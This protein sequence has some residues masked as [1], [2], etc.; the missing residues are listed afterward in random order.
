VR[1]IARPSHATPVR[2]IDRAVLVGADG[3]P[4]SQYLWV[5][6]KTRSVNVIFVVYNGN[7][8]LFD[9]VQIN[10]QFELGGRISSSVDANTVDLELFQSWSDV[11]RLV[12]RGP[13]PGRATTPALHAHTAFFPHSPH[14]SFD[15]PE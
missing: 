3:V 15:P 12:H 11:G 8:G 9:V 13:G 4:S 10:F 2:P 5:D 14:P 6:E 7:F 1:L